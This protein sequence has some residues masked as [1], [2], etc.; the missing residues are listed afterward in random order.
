MVESVASLLA[1]QDEL[2]QQLSDPAIHAD[3]GRAKKVNRRYAELSQI[4]TAHTQWQQ[5]QEDLAAAR[6]L[7]SRGSAGARAAAGEA[8]V[9]QDERRVP[10]AGQQDHPDGSRTPRS[11]RG[12]GRLT[13]RE[14]PRGER[15]YV[16]GAQFASQPGEMAHLFTGSGSRPR[17]HPDS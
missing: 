1:E 16:S 13:T 10:H 11:P 5:A 15:R 6:A 2:A 9:D 3:A 12:R 7:G 17:V 14:W 4:V 8:Q